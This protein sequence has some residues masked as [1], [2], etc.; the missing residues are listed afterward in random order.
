MFHLQAKFLL[1]YGLVLINCPN[2][3]WIFLI[4]Y[5]IKMKAN[6]NFV[7]SLSPEEDD[8]TNSVFSRLLSLRL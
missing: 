4:I 6:S 1:T 2:I 7:I 8:A 5:C 3:S